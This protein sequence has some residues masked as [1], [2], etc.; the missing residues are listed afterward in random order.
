MRR[1]FTRQIDILVLVE[2]EGIDGRIIV[3]EMLRPNERSQ[4]EPRTSVDRLS[5]CRS[6]R[7]VDDTDRFLSLSRGRRIRSHDKQNIK[8][9]FGDATDFQANCCRKI[10]GGGNEEQ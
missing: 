2:I 10:R 3:S 6:D 8:Q 9:L 7:G 5:F 1:Y 4:D